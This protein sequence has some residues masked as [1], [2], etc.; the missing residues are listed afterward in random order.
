MA[1]STREKV[2]TAA[3]ELLQTRSFNG[4]SFDD[5]AKR[6]GIRKP[7]LYHHFKSKNELALE[8]LAQNAARLEAAARGDS[9][10]SGDEQLR[11][12]LRAIGDA[13]CAGDRLCPGGA[14]VASWGVL[15]REI[16]AG[17]RKLRELHHQWLVRILEQGYRDGTIRRTGRSA[18]DAALWIFATIQGALVVARASGERGQYDVVAEQLRSALVEPAG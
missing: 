9:G 2:V 18:D 17:V 5:L 13:L 10:K 16:R 12:H 1:V 6:V 4:F 3:Q 15:P 7:S 14:L 8:L 11:G